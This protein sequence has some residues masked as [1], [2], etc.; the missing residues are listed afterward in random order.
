MQGKRVLSIVFKTVI[1]T[2]KSLQMK[3]RT[4][5]RGPLVNQIR[6]GWTESR[7]FFLN[8]LLKQTTKEG[9]KKT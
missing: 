8:N 3:I 2:K 6:S 1:Y 9:R 7:T 4:I 5:L